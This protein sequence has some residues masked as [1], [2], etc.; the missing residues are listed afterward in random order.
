MDA[1]LKKALLD[2]EGGV[3]SDADI[4]A[5]DLGADAG[6]GEVGNWNVDTFREVLECDPAKAIVARQVV[7]S[8]RTSLA[9][10]G[11]AEQTSVP[12]FPPYLTKGS[13]ATGKG[14]VIGYNPHDASQY[15]TDERSGKMYRWDGKRKEKPEDRWPFGQPHEVAIVRHT[16]VGGTYVPDEQQAHDAN[17]AE[18]DWYHHGYNC[19]IGKGGKPYGNVPRE[20]RDAVIVAGERLRREGGNQLIL[21]PPRAA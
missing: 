12:D 13:V 7:G 18:L 17:S 5:I 8:F 11:Q 6:L 20:V 16:N 2:V 10:N 1:A 15:W 9:L 3:F 4:D 14:A 21:R 19:W